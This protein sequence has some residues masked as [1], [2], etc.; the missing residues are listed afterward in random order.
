MRD[1][2]PP[3]RLEGSTLVVGPTNVGKTRLTAGAMRRWIGRHGPEGVVVIDLAPDL[4]VDGRRIGG[5]IERFEPVPDGVWFARVETDG[6][7]TEGVDGADTAGIAAR[8][9]DRATRAFR[10]APADPVAVFVNDVTLALHDDVGRVGGITAYCDRA[11]C[12]VVNA[13]E[14][15]DLD[16]DDAISR[17]E[18]EAVR[19]LVDWADRVVRP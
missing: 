15:G 10:A 13:H 1:G 5:P 17:R 3:I 2:S 9:A 12:A 18:R 19:R 14:G 6:P 7:R 4:V 16:R 11:R 8:N